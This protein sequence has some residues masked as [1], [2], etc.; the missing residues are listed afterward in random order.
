MIRRKFHLERRGDKLM[1]KQEAINFITSLSDHTKVHVVVQETELTKSVI[2]LV[3]SILKTGRF[4][5]E[6]HYIDS[7]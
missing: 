7:Q 1:T 6:M 3:S 5:K 2:Y 4:I